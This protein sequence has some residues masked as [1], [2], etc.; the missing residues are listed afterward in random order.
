[1]SYLV[2]ARKWRPSTFEAVVGQ[3]HVTETLRN[4]IRRGRIGHAFLFTG[5][6]GVGKTTIARILARALNCQAG[7]GPAEEP[8]GSCPSCQSILAGASVDVFEI[9]GASNNSVED[10]R[11]LR[12]NAQYVPSSSRYK[13]YIVDEVHMLSKGA[14]NALLKVL[15]EPPEHVVF[16]F[17]TTE[18]EKVPI[19]VLSRCQRYDLKRVRSSE[20]AAHLRRLAD[21]EGFAIDD[22]ALRLLARQAD[23]S[24]RD[25]LSLLDQVISFAG[26]APS[27]E[28]VREIL[29]AV[30][31]GLITDTVDALLAGDGG[32]VLALTDRALETGIEPRR[33]LAELTAELR[34][35]AVARICP[36][37]PE[38]LGLGG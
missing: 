23:G 26:D 21:S 4:A 37:R 2:L 11:N 10:V 1:M 15:E 14:F 33:L 18:P 38:L 13:I 29:G 24:L 20:I 34:N 16:M 9:D 27:A 32:A 28:Q 12:E 17:A 31:R 6:R 5:V 7:D 22:E 35:L 25:S 30:D 36:G 19:T 3:Q 8:C